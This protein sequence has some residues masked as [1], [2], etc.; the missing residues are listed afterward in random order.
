MCAVGGVDDL[1][2]VLG[3]LM[4]MGILASMLGGCE[5]SEEEPGLEDGPYVVVSVE[6][7]E[8]EDAERWV[9]GEE[10]ARRWF[11]EVLR[12]S[13]RGLAEEGSGLPVRVILEKELRLREMGSKKQLV[14]EF[15]AQV[16][17]SQLSGVVPELELT[18]EAE[19]VHALKEERPDDE[20][21]EAMSNSLGRKA[22]QESMDVLRLLAVVR[23][24]E[25][26]ELVR[27]SRTSTFGEE[28]RLLAIQELARREVA[29]AVPVLKTATKAESAA[30]AVEAAEALYALKRNDAAHLV[31]D[32]A[33]RMS[34][35]EYYDEYLRLLSTVG[36][37][38]EPWVSIYLE[39]VAQAHTNYR[40]RQKARTLSAERPLIQ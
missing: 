15:R 30:V 35:D 39:T 38:D 20:V 11:Q 36:K 25:P 10:D 4:V 29:G 33:Q 34:R 7:Q 8:S 2:K 12:K 37:L 14:M 6:L 24:G 18:T 23:Q 17:E 19:Y 3:G 5:D 9:P 27:W 26:W 1:K 16:V 28:K 13:E 40:A 32:V 21:L 22:A 31:M